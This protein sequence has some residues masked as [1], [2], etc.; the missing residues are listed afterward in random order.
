MSTP[1]RLLLAALV[2][3]TASSCSM[4]KAKG[5]LAEV[6]ELATVVGTLEA[7][8]GSTQPL[9]VGL[10]RDEAGQKSLAAY[11]VRYGTGPFRFIVPAGN[12]HLVA[13]ED[14]NGNIRFDAGEAGYYE[15]DRKPPTSLKAGS[16]VNVGS[17]RMEVRTVDVTELKI[18]ADRDLA[19]SPELTS[20]HRGTV[21]SWDDPRFKVESGKEGMWTP[22]AAVATHGAGMFFLEP[23]DPNRIPVI[24]VHGMSG[25]ARDLKELAEKLDRRRFQAW[26]FQYPSGIRLGIAGELLQAMLAEMRARHRYERYVVI[27]HS[28]G[29]LVSRS[30]L[31]KTKREGGMPPAVFLTISTPWDGH[32]AAEIGTKRS[33]VVLHSWFDMAPGSPLLRDLFSAQLDPSTSTHLLFGYVGGNGSDGTVTL[34]SMLRPAAQEAAVRVLGFPEDHTSILASKEVIGTVNGI[35]ARSVK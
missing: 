12:Y 4:Y 10:F 17:I 16:D 22:L 32:A 25:T 1:I 21:V 29:G 14:L 31:L 28:A 2:A 26:F 35:L 20:F 5:D 19:S 23:Y 27:A 7:P 8:P 34:K 15:G 30:A 9:V 33:P 3:A 11:F 6:A 18:A 24:F 13:F